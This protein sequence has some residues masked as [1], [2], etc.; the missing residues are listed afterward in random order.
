MVNQQVQ[1]TFILPGYTG[2]NN[3]TTAV[4]NYL[5]ARNNPVS[6]PSAYIVERCPTG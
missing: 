5:K 3:D 2:A 6:S 4:A 1:A